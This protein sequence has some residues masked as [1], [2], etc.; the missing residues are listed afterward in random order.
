MIRNILFDV[1]TV[2]LHINYEPALALTHRL[3]DPAKRD[4]LRRFFTFDD[5]DPMIREYELGAITTEEFFKHFADVTGFSGTMDQFVGTYR[6]MLSEN[7][8]MLKFARELSRKHNVYLVTNAGTLHTPDIYDRFPSLRFFKDEASSCY[9]GAVKP[10]AAYYEKALTKFGITSDTCLLV[11][12]RPENVAGAEAF[13][14]R[15]ILYTTPDET[16][17]AVRKTLG[18]A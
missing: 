9:L 16:I 5:R 11:D 14:I 15:A 17:A 2:L 10:D 7:K 8:P 4:A 6:D 18:R 12:D 3:C 13:G 1:G